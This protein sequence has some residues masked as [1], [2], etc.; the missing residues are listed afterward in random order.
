M[1]ELF[2][3]FDHFTQS[4]WPYAITLLISVISAIRIYVGGTFCDST[5]R[6][7]SKNVI[8]TGGARGIGLE[9]AK[10]LAKRGAHIILAIRN[11][12]K[13]RKAAEQIKKQTPGARVVIKLLD[14]S[15]F[16]VIRDFVDQIKNEYD[17]IDILI[18][19]AGIISHPN[20]KTVDGNELTF[21]TNYLG[22]FLLTHLLLP[23]L[24]KSDNGRVINISALAH[25]NGKLKLD[26]L[27]SEKQFNEKGCFRPK[28][29]G[30]HHVHQAHGHFV[31][32][33][34]N[35]IQCREPRTGEEHGS[36]RKVFDLS[37]SFFT[38][39]SVWPWMWLFLK[40]PKQGCQS[41]VYLAVEPA[42]NTVSGCYFS[43]CEIQ[44]PAEVVKDQNL[45]KIL[46]EKSCNIV[47]IDPSKIRLM[48]DNKPEV[49]NEKSVEES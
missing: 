20:R 43:N 1:Q 2:V 13:G 29:T 48:E 31:Q 22:P 8:I 38:K 4:W 33:Y 7:D 5:C 3:D 21:L 40:T 26:D 35:N 16:S 49:P 24:S 19:N 32:R 25:F 15:D 46:Y 47:N 23:V 42:L 11:A 36:Y 34:E 30:S 6:I 17:K 12:E 44:E 28:Q 39:L 41:I 10:E 18:N 27:N 45:A 14:L 37:H 9:T